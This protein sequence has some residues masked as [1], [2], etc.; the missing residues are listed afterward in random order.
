MSSTRNNLLAGI[1]V[2]LAIV[3]S[4]VAVIVLAGGAEQLGQSSYTVS[5]GL[6][7]DVG[8]TPGAAVKIGGIKVG[9][10]RK[11]DF[12]KNADGAIT[13]TDVAIGIKSTYRLHEGASPVLKL[14]LLGS[15]GEINFPFVG[16]GALLE[17]GTRMDGSLAAPSF[18]SQAGYGDDQAKQLQSI[19]KN[20]DEAMTKLNDGA[21]SVRSMTDDAAK[22]WPKWSERIDSITEK[23][24]ATLTK[25]PELAEDI[26]SRLDQIE[27]VLA[28]A[29]GYLDENRENI[30]AGIADF[31]AIADKGK[32]FADRLNGELKDS[33]MA[34]LE[35]GKSTL[36]DARTFITNATEIVGEQRPNIRRTFAN[37]R[38]ASDQLRDTLIEVRRS[39]W[40]LIYRPD[41]RELNFELLY[42]AARSYA[43]A[44]SDLRAASES[45]ESLIASGPNPQLLREGSID[46]LVAQIQ[47]AMDT[48]QQ[49]EQKFM[50]QLL[51]QPAPDAATK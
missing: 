17:P 12:S 45:L 19:L 40:R 28:T 11:V 20:T 51:A 36:D 16:T 33:A 47:R 32:A 49:A 37:I 24:D 2:T 14:P 10:V 3:G 1:L 4:V 6:D 5:F 23:A 46:E 22:K 42:D 27:K 41:T 26:K 18:L 25:G 31:R 38:L 21:T 34:L 8:L 13:G 15:Q 7:T 35:K 48:Y 44:V 29:Q 43:G 39:P 50:D 30:K 9:S